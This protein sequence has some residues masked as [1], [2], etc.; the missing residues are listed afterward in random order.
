[1]KT[2][3]RILG[4]LSAPFLLC[5]CTASPMMTVTVHESK[6]QVVRLQTTPDANGGQGYSHPAFLSEQ[7][8]AAVL[9]GLYVETDTSLVPLAL[10]PSQPGT[11]SRAFGDTEVTF[12]APLLVKGLSKATP[13]ELVTFFETAD[14]SSTQRVVTSGGV[15]VIGEELHVVLSNHAT[16]V[17]IWQDADTY[18]APYRLTPLE[19][20]SP[21]PGRLSFE[22]HRH[23]VRSQDSALRDRLAS[24]VLHIAV[25][26]RELQETSAPGSTDGSNPAHSRTTTAPSPS[27]SSPPGD[28]GARDAHRTTSASDFQ[29]VTLAGSGG[30]TECA[31]DGSGP[32]G[33]R[34]VGR[35]AF[36][37]FPHMNTTRGHVEQ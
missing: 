15:F 31:R 3:S 12:L 4:S 19:P 34:L 32:L 18:A 26:F 16:K 5:A 25:R 35:L 21:E 20:I 11:R 9:K 8:V 6:N 7:T 36:P 10:R 27:P 33:I 29:D 2:I 23:M 22:P 14:I 1:M 24:G 37:A 28:R 30:S 17:H 13:Q